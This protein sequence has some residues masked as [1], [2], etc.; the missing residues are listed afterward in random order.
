MVSKNLFD[1]MPVMEMCADHK[2][3]KSSIIPF[4]KSNTDLL[5]LVSEDDG[6]TDSI[7]QVIIYSIVCSI[8]HCSICLFIKE[9]SHKTIFVFTQVK[10][11]KDLLQES[12]KE[13]YR[14]CIYEGMGHIIDLPYLPPV[15]VTNH[16]YFPK[17]IEVLMGGEDKLAHTKG[18]I[19]LWHDT[20]DFLR[21]DR[22][23]EF[24]PDH[25]DDTWLV[26]NKL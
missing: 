22:T 23:L 24:S 8:Q 1:L 11:A 2:N 3:D 19:K 20:L 12:G 21:R 14:I 17:P 15:H 10:Y 6:V 18:Q 13:N 9:Y 25:S 5:F 16:A 4:A 7:G 26:N